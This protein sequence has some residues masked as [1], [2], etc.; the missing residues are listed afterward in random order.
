MIKLKPIVEDVS[1]KPMMSL[2]EPPRKLT[3][4]EKKTLAELVHN[5]NEYGRV[6]R[7]YDEIANVAETLKKIA[8]YSEVYA[9]N[10]CGDWMQAGVAKRHFAEIKKHAEG[11][12]KLAKE[13]HEKNAHM[14][15]LYEDMGSVLEKYFEIKDAEK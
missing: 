9:V 8:E 13:V 12:K 15:A 11:F 4:D 10:E 3:K 2:E 14:I 5:Y 6:L 1:S 7:Q